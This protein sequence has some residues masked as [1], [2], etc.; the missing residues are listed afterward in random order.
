MSPGILWGILGIVAFS[1]IGF[2][3]L[4]AGGVL[5][6]LPPRARRIVT[7]VGW[8]AYALFLSAV[9]YQSLLMERGMVERGHLSETS[10]LW[11]WVGSSILLAVFTVRRIA[12]ALLQSNDQTGTGASA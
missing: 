11:A 3:A 2:A 7:S 6:R 10:A 5:G 1:L 12:R 9:I 8:A 4:S